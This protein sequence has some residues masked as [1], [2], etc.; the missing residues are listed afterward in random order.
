MK[1]V[2]QFAP[3]ALLCLW[4]SCAIEPEQINYGSDACHFCKMTIVDQEHS[5]Q[6]VTNKGKQYKFDAIE[7]LVNELSE[8]DMNE[9]GILLVADYSN[10]GEMTKANSAT[11]LISEGIKSPMGANLSGFSKAAD[12]EGA[13]VEHGGQLYDWQ[14]LLQKFEVD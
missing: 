1:R 2:Y 4:V 5:A 13:K 12:A 3:M 8:K 6:Y 9:I 11:Y 7:C 10:P 14:A